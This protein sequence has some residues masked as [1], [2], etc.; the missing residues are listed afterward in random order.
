[1]TPTSSLRFFAPCPRGLE[2]I[3]AEELHQLEAENIQTTQGG[4]G[5]SGHLST[6]MQA[7][8]HSRVASRILWKLGEKAYQSEDDLYDFARY[9]IDWS[10]F[11]TAQ[12]TMKV[13]VTAIKTTLKSTSFAGL[14]VKD[15][16]CDYFRFKTGARPNIH[17]HTPD[18]RIHLFLTQQIATIYLDTSGE[19]L[20]KRGYRQDAG[21][22]PLREN[23]AAGL[24]MLTGWKPY[25]TFYDPLCGSGTLLAEAAMIARC[26]APGLGRSFAFQQLRCHVKSEWQQQIHQAKSQENKGI[27]PI[28]GSDLSET[29]LVRTRANLTKLGIKDTVTVKQLNVLDARPPA[30]LGKQHDINVPGVW[31][32]NPPYG[33]RLKNTCIIKDNPSNTYPLWGNLLKQHFS[34]WRAYFFTNDL[35]LAKEIGLKATKRIVLFNGGLEC[36]LFEYRMQ[37]GR[38]QKHPSLT[39]SAEDCF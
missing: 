33:I 5:F 36:R 31:L 20:F 27:F 29:A 28:Y 24:I 23:L 8:L 11:F 26:I 32:C 6:M 15:G 39:T 30:A 4:V 9:Y 3:L 7:N 13:V 19:A 10:D 1:M 25:Q 14:K 12:N 22:A 35:H 37:S 34:G 2:S 17:L 16:I 21:E 18:I 38:L